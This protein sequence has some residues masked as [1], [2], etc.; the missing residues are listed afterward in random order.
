[1]RITIIMMIPIHLVKIFQVQLYKV[2][3]NNNNNNRLNKHLNKILKIV[4]KK[5]CIYIYIYGLYPI[6]I[7]G[8]KVK[9][10]ESII[11][12]LHFVRI[13]KVSIVFKKKFENYKMA[14]QG[15]LML[16]L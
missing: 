13:T 2:N 12:F 5:I 15:G 9:H 3:N 7:L 8:E 10:L 4:K 14:A 6:K 1:M 11:V 16:C